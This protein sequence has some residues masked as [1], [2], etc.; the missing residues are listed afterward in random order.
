M[1]GAENNSDKENEVSFVWVGNATN[2]AS[3]YSDLTDGGEIFI[4]ESAYRVLSDDLKKDRWNK[5]VKSKGMKIYN[6]YASSNFYLD[7]ANELGKTVLPEHDDSADDKKQ[8]ENIIKAVSDTYEKLVS[9][10]KNL[11]VQEEKL[12]RKEKDIQ[13]HGMSVYYKLLGILEE[14]YCHDDIVKGS[15]IDYWQHVVCQIYELGK[16]LKR[17]EESIR[18]YLAAYLV[19]IYDCLGAYNKAFD[20]M[21]YMAEHSTWVSL[22]DKTLKWAA[23][24]DKI[25]DLSFA[26]EWR[27]EHDSSGISVSAFKEYLDEVRK[28][29]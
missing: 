26:L 25:F 3:K 23:E 4:S 6:G 17:D 8:L 16:V 14:A 1:Y 7:F 24:K 15:D 13:A 29:G 21:E 20:E 5:V 18:N 9:R 12:N 2:H 11:A 28:Y 27:I 10:E 19:Y 22:E